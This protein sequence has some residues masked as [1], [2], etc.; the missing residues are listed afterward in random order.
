MREI[1]FRAWH[2]PEDKDDSGFMFAVRRIDFDRMN[3]GDPAK[4]VIYMDHDEPTEEGVEYPDI[5]FWGD[6][7][8][9]M[10]YTGL[11]DKNGKEIY[12]GDIVVDSWKHVKGKVEWHDKKPKFCIHVGRSRIDL[13]WQTSLVEIIGNI[14]ENPEMIQ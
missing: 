2:I 5:W 8:E 10:Q 7:V 12:E 6:G 9:L 4:F 11:H 14:Y 3:T 13:E 1:K